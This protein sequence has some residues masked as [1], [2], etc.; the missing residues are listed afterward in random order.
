[1]SE[2]ALLADHLD[3]R[4]KAILAVWRATVARVGDVPE[5][6]RLTD[7]EFL[8]HVPA[9]LD[10]LADRLRGQPADAVNE[11]K[12]HGKYRWRQGYDIGQI[13]NEFAHLR[14]ALCRSTLE[15]ARENDWGLDRFEAAHEAIDEV[16]AE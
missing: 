14:T 4:A 15:F 8:D 6:E 5:A 11:G 12:E 9:L 1:M 3:Q 7:A 10:R 16:L 2:P 13:I